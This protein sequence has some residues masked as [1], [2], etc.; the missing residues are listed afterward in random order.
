MGRPYLAKSR[1]IAEALGGDLALGYCDL[2]KG[3][4]QVLRRGVTGTKLRVFST[5]V[6]GGVEGSAT[7]AA[8]RLM[9][10]GGRLSCVTT[11]VNCFWY[12][13]PPA[14]VAWTRIA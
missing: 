7:L 5:L 10:V 1:R 3:A 8:E 12:D 2:P 11:M 4:R 6:V 14:S 13:R 9:S